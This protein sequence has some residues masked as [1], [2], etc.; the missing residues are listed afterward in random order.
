MMDL[1]NLT[2]F[3]YVAQLGSFTKA[4]QT[5]G[6]SQSTLSFQIRQLEEELGFPLFERINRMWC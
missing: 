4:G 1:K 6:C 5:L 2:T 3:T